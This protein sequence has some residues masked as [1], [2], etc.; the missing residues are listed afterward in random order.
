M[1]LNSM[2][3]NGWQRLWIIISVLWFFTLSVVFYDSL[4][5][6]KSINIFDIVERLPDKALKVLSKPVISVD[7]QKKIASFRKDNPEYKNVEDV[8]LI[9][10]I[11]KNEYAKEM[12]RD[13]FYLQLKDSWKFNPEIKRIPLINGTDVTLAPDTSPSDIVYMSES[14]NAAINAQLNKVR[15]SFALKMLA[16]WAVPCAALYLFGLTLNWVYKGFKKQ[17]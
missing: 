13:A 17:D 14:A 11:Y 15:I 8:D 5:S 10:T 2:K 12:S 16:L 3:L 4:P 6:A 9:E 1:K 7:L